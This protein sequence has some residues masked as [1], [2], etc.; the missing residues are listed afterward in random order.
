MSTTK[1]AC[2]VEEIDTLALGMIKDKEDSFT[3]DDPEQPRDFDSWYASRRIVRLVF[4]L[5]GF[6]DRVIKI[7]EVIPESTLRALYRRGPVAIQT[8]SHLFALGEEGNLS[9]VPL[10]KVAKL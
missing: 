10:V 1:D 3:A 8:G 6:T 9:I 2:Y 4:H 7:D 5:A